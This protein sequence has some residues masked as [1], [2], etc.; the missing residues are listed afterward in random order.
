[1]ILLYCSKCNILIEVKM[2]S[3]AEKQFPLYASGNV[4]HGIGRG[5]KQLGFPTGK[6]VSVVNWLEL[7]W[8]RFLLNWLAM[9]YLLGI[10]NNM[11]HHKTYF[12]KD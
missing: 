12:I 5:S 4:I 10:N 7:A 3:C 1:M 11:A 9:L 2:F 6:H 8:I